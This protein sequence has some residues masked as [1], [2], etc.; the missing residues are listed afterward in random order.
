LLSC[1]AQF[2]HSVQSPE[3][4]SPVRLGWLIMALALSCRVA[5]VS[6]LFPFTSEPYLNR[7][8]SKY[9]YSLI[10]TAKGFLFHSIMY[11]TPFHTF[12]VTKK[13]ENTN[14]VKPCC[15]WMK[16]FNLCVFIFGLLREILVV[17]LYNW[18]QFHWLMYWKKQESK[19][20]ERTILPTV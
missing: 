2:V 12:N 19:V 11:T 6:P 1:V 8:I 5:N 17:N 9:F 7:Y 4:N 16:I 10:S 13:N 14:H 20:T 15:P 3:Q 18:E